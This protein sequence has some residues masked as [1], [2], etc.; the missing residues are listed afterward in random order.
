MIVIDRFS[1]LDVYIRLSCAGICSR[2]GTLQCTLN[3]Y[4]SHVGNACT[5]PLHDTVSTSKGGDM[6]YVPY[7]SINMSDRSSPSRSKLKGKMKIN[8][9]ILAVVM[10]WTRSPNFRLN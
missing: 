2:S 7:G 4:D 3:V 1:G 8:E 9:E 10:E 5:R 6:L